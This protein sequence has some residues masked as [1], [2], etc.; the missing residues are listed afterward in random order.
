MALS[1]GGWAL[2]SGPSYS[3]SGLNLIRI[4]IQTD[5]NHLNF[6]PPQKWLSR[7]KKIE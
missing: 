7:A 1:R 5:S 3:A 4:Q 6:Q 2:M